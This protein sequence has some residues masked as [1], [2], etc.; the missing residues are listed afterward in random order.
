MKTW[1]KITHINDIP[2]MGSRILQYQEE[3][4]VLFKNRKE[5]IFA[6]NNV[7]PH[8]QGKLSEGM[9]HGKSVTCPLHNWDIDL[10]TG[11]A[12]GSDSGCTKVYESKVE[13]EMIYVLL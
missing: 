12:L 10:E 7:C 6:L 3:E 2:L 11:E 9:V 8:K 1:K 5:E 4:I 13:E